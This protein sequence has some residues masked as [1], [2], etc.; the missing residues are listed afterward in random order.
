MNQHTKLED[1]LA[2]IVAVTKT[3]PPNLQ[4]KCFELLLTD[5]LATRASRQGGDDSP[6]EGAGDEAL[7]GAGGEDIQQTDLHVK[8]RKF[9][10]NNDLTVQDINQLFYKEDS[11]LKPLYDDLHTTTMSEAQTRIAL[12]QAL[13]SGLQ[14]GDFTFEKESVRAEAQQRKCYDQSNFSANFK[15]NE[16]LFEAYESAATRLS[17]S[18][19]GRN[20]LATLVRDLVRT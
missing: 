3:V 20:T 14:T 12:L 5:F 19:T 16:G 18:T 15:N 8:A 17:L 10:Q 13:H 11:E 6:Q 1:T 4:E 2:E 9:L 7:T